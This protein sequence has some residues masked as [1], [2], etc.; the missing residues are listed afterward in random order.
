MNLYRRYNW[1]YF[2][3][4]TDIG[5]CHDNAWCH[6]DINMERSPIC[7]MCTIMLEKPLLSVKSAWKYS[8]PLTYIK[9]SNLS[10]YGKYLN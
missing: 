4:I 2:E 1:W 8:E 7:I 10:S 5:R 6:D 3:A 9:I